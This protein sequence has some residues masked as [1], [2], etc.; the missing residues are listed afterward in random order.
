MRGRRPGGLLVLLLAAPAAPDYTLAVSAQRYLF[1]IVHEQIAVDRDNSWSISP[2][3]G[4]PATIY[5]PNQEQ[6]NPCYGS[7]TRCTN[8]RIFR[9]ALKATF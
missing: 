1:N 8:P 3:S 2:P 4:F 6:T 9:A 5:D 7:V